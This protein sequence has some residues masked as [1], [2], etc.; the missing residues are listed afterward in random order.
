MS[1]AGIFIII[2]LILIAVHT[3]VVY[4]WLCRKCCPLPSDKPV[5]SPE[6]DSSSLRSKA[7]WLVLFLTA[8][9][10]AFSTTVCG[11]CH[12]PASNMRLASG[13]A[14]VKNYLK[15]GVKVSLGV[16][17]SASNDSGHLLN[18]A[19]LA[20]LL[21]RVMG[22]PAGMTAEQALWIATRGGAQNLGRD[23][24]GQ[25]APG[26][27][28]DVAAYRLD[29]IDFAGGLHDP[30]A[31]LTFCGP[32]KADFVVVNGKVRV[33]DGQLVDVDLP[34]LLARHNAIAKAL[35]NG[36]LS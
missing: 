1:L 36:E 24:I 18:E 25:L 20:L 26:M 31:A 10:L 29:T 13:I 15:A 17:G 19:R 4:F 16:D 14:P 35:V 6:T 34:P 33:Q 8:A 3:V 7:Q 32:V 9:S 30:M 2:L 23:D 27:A 22:D 5:L 12:C 11:M 28:A 21:Q